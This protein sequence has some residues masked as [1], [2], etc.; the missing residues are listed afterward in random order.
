MEGL[1]QFIPSGIT[2]GLQDEQGIVSGVEED[3][4][5]MVQ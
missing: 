1:P 4:G 3:A 5:M 2:I